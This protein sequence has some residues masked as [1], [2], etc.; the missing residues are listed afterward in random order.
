MAGCMAAAGSGTERRKYKNY[1]TNPDKRL[2]ST[3]LQ[4]GSYRHVGV[5]GVERMNIRSYSAFRFALA[6][7][8]AACFAVCGQ[9]QQSQLPETFH[10]ED[11]ERS[12]GP[13]QVK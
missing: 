9:A 7:V 5:L 13:Y 10:L 1:Q 2:L 12:L 8:M 6:L 4:L 3:V 11:F